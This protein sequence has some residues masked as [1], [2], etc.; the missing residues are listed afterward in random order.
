MNAQQIE[1]TRNLIAA[2]RGGEY[3]QC[4]GFYRKTFGDGSVKHCVAG[5]AYDLLAKKGLVKWTDSLEFGKSS[6]PVLVDSDEDYFYDGDRQGIDEEYGISSSK[7]DDLVRQNNTGTSFADLASRI[8]S[9]I[10]A[11]VEA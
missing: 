10:P 11:A 6:R 5:V 3:V 2:L 9:M 8:E 1:N 4:R 7:W